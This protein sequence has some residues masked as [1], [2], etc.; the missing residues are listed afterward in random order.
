VGRMVGGNQSRHQAPA[1]RAEIA[2][3]RP[4]PFSHSTDRGSYHASR[5]R[6]NSG[7]RYA[8]MRA[9]TQKGKAVG[10]ISYISPEQLRGESVDSRTDLFALG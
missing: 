4:S 6:Y 1:R 8:A 7:N 9:V 5:R 3:S 2:S 10:T